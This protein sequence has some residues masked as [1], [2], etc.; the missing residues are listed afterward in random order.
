MLALIAVQE[1]TSTVSGSLVVYYDRCCP[2][3]VTEMENP[4]GR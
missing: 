2:L 1:A 3:C 4:E